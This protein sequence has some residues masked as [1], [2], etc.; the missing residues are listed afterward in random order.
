METDWHGLTRGVVSQGW[1]WEPGGLELSGR[2]GDVPGVCGLGDVPRG[3][4]GSAEVAGSMDQGKVV[5]QVWY[6]DRER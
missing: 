5:H 1:E 3:L 4:G 6:G 2:P